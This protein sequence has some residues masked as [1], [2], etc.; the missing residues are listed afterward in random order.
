MG[1]VTKE[2]KSDTNGYAWFKDMDNQLIAD[3]CNTR[4]DIDAMVLCMWFVEKNTER[5]QHAVALAPPN[6]TKRLKAYN[7]KLSKAKTAQQIRDTIEVW[8][9]RKPLYS[10]VKDIKEEVLDTCIDIMKGAGIGINRRRKIIPLL[11][12]HLMYDEE[13]LQ[14]PNQRL[15][16]LIE[17]F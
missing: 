15:I 6:P 13:L 1:R 14:E 17:S 11:T 12:W 3:V 5:Y 16:D 10:D 4:K 8:K 7:N 9:S 2:Q